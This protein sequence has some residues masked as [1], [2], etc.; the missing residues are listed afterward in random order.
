VRSG[1][2]AVRK[3]K[4]ETPRIM[5]LEQEGKCPLEESIVIHVG[6]SKVQERFTIDIY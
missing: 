2:I 3:A 6:V 1:D 4:L 5:S